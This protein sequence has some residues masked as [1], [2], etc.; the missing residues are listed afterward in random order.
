[1]IPYELGM[2]LSSYSLGISEHLN[3]SNNHEIES[4]LISDFLIF[5]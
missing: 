2:S 4:S 1:M 5:L 3:I